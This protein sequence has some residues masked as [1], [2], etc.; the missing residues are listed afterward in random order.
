MEEKALCP[1]VK[2]KHFSSEESSSSTE[3]V[4]FLTTDTCSTGESGGS[5]SDPLCFFPSE[6]EKHVDDESVVS[7]NTPSPVPSTLA[8]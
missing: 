3:D 5:D 6:D 8:I 1:P 2:R 7:N 4:L